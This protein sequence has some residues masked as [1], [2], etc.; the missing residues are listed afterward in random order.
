[1]AKRVYRKAALLPWYLRGPISETAS[2]NSKLMALAEH[3]RLG[4]YSEMLHSDSG[5]ELTNM[6]SKVHALQ[7]QWRALAECLARDLVDGFDGPQEVYERGRR[8]NSGVDRWKLYRT[9]HRLIRER[10]SK[11]KSL[12]VREAITQLV[13]RDGS[14]P[15]F[16][17]KNIDTLLNVYRSAH[18]QMQELQHYATAKSCPP[19][20]K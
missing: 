16:R 11:G 17:R 20:S 15:E 4:V 12:T 6:R 9:V 2:A 19:G 13:S 5:D 3:Y 7:D 1:M 14:E 18:R 10:V 8:K